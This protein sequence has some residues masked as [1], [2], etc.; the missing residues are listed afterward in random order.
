[1]PDADQYRKRDF[2]RPHNKVQVFIGM[3]SQSLDCMDGQESG[4]LRLNRSVFCLGWVLTSCATVKHYGDAKAT[5]EIHS[6]AGWSRKRY[7]RPGTE[8]PPG[9]D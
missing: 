8:A 2:N 9:T 5:T 1:M 3:T 7:Q 4:E 6:A